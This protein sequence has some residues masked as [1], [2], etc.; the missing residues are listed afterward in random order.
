MCRH[1]DWYQ[2]D[3]QT[4]T[5]APRGLFWIDF[6]PKR[7]FHVPSGLQI[8]ASTD[9]WAHPKSSI[10]WIQAGESFHAGWWWACLTCSKILASW[11][12]I[13]HCVFCEYLPIDYSVHIS[14][15]RKVREGVRMQSGM[16]ATLF[17]T[18]TH[19]SDFGNLLKKQIAL[20]SL[21][22][23]TPEFPK[24]FDYTAQCFLDP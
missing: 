19:T 23:I 24:M 13:C 8:I 5:V 2:E 11:Q 14:L 17:E 20:R 4:F 6:K 12:L 10:Q 22:W 3:Q 16:E 18:Q 1:Q 9:F 21:L 15:P 7:D